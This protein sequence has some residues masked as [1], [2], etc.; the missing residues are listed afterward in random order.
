MP[1]DAQDDQLQV[2]IPTLLVSN[3]ARAVMDI[4]RTSRV[5]PEFLVTVLTA[6]CAFATVL[7]IAM[8]MLA[9]DDLNQRMK[10]MAMERDK[11]RAARL[12]EIGQKDRPGVK[13]R[14]QP[15]G[16][17]QQIV[18]IAQSA[19]EVRQRG[20]C[21]T[22]LKAAGL[23]GQAPARRLHVLPRRDAASS[24]SS[25]TLFYL[26]VLGDYQL[27]AADQDP[28]GVRRWVRWLLPAEHLRLEPRLQSA[29]CRSSR[30]FRT[31]STCC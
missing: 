8:P 18:D 12:A 20:D 27:S 5:D 22:K 17:M 28:D 16:F 10:V 30:H 31:R 21:A 9:R 25:L 3:R 19:L 1:G 7:T 2:L 11:M 26:F 13:L 24:F 6:I 4:D 15:K 29:S 23:R 14:Q